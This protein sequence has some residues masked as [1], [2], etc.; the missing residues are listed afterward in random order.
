MGGLG[1]NYACGTIVEGNVIRAFHGDGAIVCNNAL[2]LVIRNNII[3][4]TD[5]GNTGYGFGIWPD[6]GAFG[7]AIYGNTIYRTVANACYIEAGAQSTSLYWNTVFDCNGAG[8]FMRANSSNTAFENYVF[9]NHS[10]QGSGITISWCCGGCANMM[11]RNWVIDNDGAGAVLSELQTTKFA[12]PDPSRPEGTVQVFKFNPDPPKST[13]HVLDH[14]VYKLRPDSVLLR[15]EGKSYKDLASV[16]SELGQEMHGEVVT[17]FN[18]APLGLVTFRVPGTKSLGSQ[19]RCSGTPTV[20][21]GL[22]YRWRHFIKVVIF[23]SRARSAGWNCMGGAT[24]LCRR[25]A[26]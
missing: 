24:T 19:C 14:N 21:A 16:R 13:P 10:G 6:C 22:L 17:E 23:G 4:G 15:Y 11:M 8:I 3:V 2:G 9:G 25:L 12:P 5:V 7:I 20:R 1:L 18:P 26:R